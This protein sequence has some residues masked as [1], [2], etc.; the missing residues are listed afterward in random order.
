MSARA[1]ADIYNDLGTS[2]EAL[3][4]AKIE[5]TEFRRYR[6]QPYLNYAMLDLAKAYCTNDDYEKTQRLTKEIQDSAEA[7]AD[8]YLSYCANS[9]ISLNEL[10]ANKE[11]DALPVLEK[12]LDSGFAEPQDTAYLAW[13]YA[14]VGRPQ[15][16]LR[17]LNEQPIF[18][19]ALSNLSLYTTYKQLGMTEKALAALEKSD[20]VMDSQYA[21]TMSQ[22][23]TNSVSD[24]FTWK[25]QQEDVEHRFETVVVLSVIAVLCLFLLI[26]LFFTLYQKKK[27]EV[28]DAKHVLFAKQLADELG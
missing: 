7:H 25:K 8:S 3:R 11:Q 15:D 23:I 24:Y 6:M 1:L 13:A 27:R 2:K 17:I 28:V 22:G 10:K 19:K 26:L 4:Y 9:I 5:E 20:S 21:K 16:A 12:I 18:A 14:K